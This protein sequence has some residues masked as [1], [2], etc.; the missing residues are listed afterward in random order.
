MN[1]LINAI[2]L[3]LAVRNPAQTGTRQQADAPGDDRR[4][5]A[6]DVAKQVAGDNNTIQRAR[7]LD[8]DHGRAVNKLMVDLQLRELLGKN[9]IDHLAPQPA[10]GQHIGLVQTPD[11]ARRV[12]R[13]GQ[14]ATQPRNALNLGP[15]VGLGIHGKSGAVILGA[16]AKVDTTSKLA[17]DDKV[18]AAANLGLER[19]VVDEGFR[20]KAAGAQVAVGAELLAQLQDALLRADGRRGAP[21]GPADGAEEDGVG[22]FGSREGLVGQG[23]VVDFDR[24]LRSG[25]S[26]VRHC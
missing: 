14:E 4:L 6:D 8:H 11:L 24:G 13:E 7:V 26:L 9:L 20:R 16:L 10:R 25:V 22:G 3:A 5:V 23:V 17:D 1:R 12:V 21:F 18:G 2:A 15:A 19:R